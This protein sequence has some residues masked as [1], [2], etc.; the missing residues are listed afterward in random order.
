M[1]VTPVSLYLSS[2]IPIM[3][4]QTIW[5]LHTH[6]HLRTLKPTHPHP[7]THPPIK[8]ALGLGSHLY[9]QIGII[10]NV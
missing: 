10:Q 5:V 2:A 7:P 4:L 3:Q 8:A 6:I 1:S 9:A